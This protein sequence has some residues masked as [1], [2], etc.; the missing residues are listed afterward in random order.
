M[1]LGSNGK[2]PLTIAIIGQFFL[3]ETCDTFGIGGVETYVSSL[4]VLFR[5]VG[6]NV[7]ILQRD[8]NREP[9]TVG[10]ARLLSWWSDAE[11]ESLIVKEV[12]ERRSLLLFSDFS[13]FRPGLRRQSAV[14]QHGV[15]WDVPQR[16]APM[17]IRGELNK[18]RKALGSFR[19]AREFANKVQAADKVITV[20]S[21]FQN[22]LRVTCPWENFE[23]KWVYVPNFSQECDAGRVEEKLSSTGPVRKVLFAR[24]FVNSRGFGLWTECVENL[25]PKFPAVTFAFCGEHRQGSA[26][27]PPAAQ[28]LHRHQNVSFFSRPYEAM[29]EEHL[30][31]DLEVVPSL[32]SEGTSLSLIEAMSAG[33]CVVSSNV[34]GLSNLLIPGF[35]GL[36][37][38]P[39]VAAFTDAVANLISKPQLARQYARHARAVSATALSKRTW[40]NRIL[41]VVSAVV[42]DA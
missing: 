6:F 21:N 19:R 42:C 28:N 5:R 32:G 41:D 15:Y 24:R 12:P 2:E 23:S 20:D 29:M 3:N 33:A 16:N 35:N 25:A 9:R 13:V 22:W 31:A 8:Q 40:E 10:G 18:I 11:L 37:V 26:A 17:G 30:S 34:G 38:P 7:V 36:L 27:W 4:L 39:T 14:V 1:H